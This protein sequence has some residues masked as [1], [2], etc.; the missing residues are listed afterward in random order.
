MTLQTFTGA[1][2]SRPR[3]IKEISFLFCGGETPPPRVMEQIAVILIFGQRLTVHILNRTVRIL[4]GRA[5]AQTTAPL[6]SLYCPSTNL[7][8]PRP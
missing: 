2:P 4:A 8:W 5:L 6:Q 1:G 7:I 3:R